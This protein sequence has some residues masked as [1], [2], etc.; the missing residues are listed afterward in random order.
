MALFQY[1]ALSP[2]GKK[3]IGLINADT[4]E[5]AKEQLRRQKILVTKLVLY[6]KQPGDQTLSSALLLNLTRDLHVLLRAGLPLYDSLLTLQEKYFRTKAHSLLLNL[7]DQVKE[8][9]HLSQAL[10]LYP[11]IFDDVYISMVRA[12]EESGTLTESFEELSKLI[13]RAQGLKK[14]ITTA[15]IY[16]LFL[17]S[18]CLVVIGALLFFLI[19]SMQELFEG[20]ALHPLTQTVLTLSSFLNENAFW[21]FSCAGLFALLSAFFMKQKSGKIFRQKMALRIPVIDRLTTEAVMTRFCRVVSVLLRGG[22]SLLDSLKLAKLVMQHHQFEEVITK[23][24]IKVV[25]GKKLS[26]ELEKSPL[27]P[28]LVIRMMAIAEES[29]NMAKMMQHVSEIYEEDLERSLSRLTS[30]MQPVILLFLGL[31]VAVILLSVLLPLTDVS[32]MIQ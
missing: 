26:E 10:A 27:I 16:P 2:N 19:P 14:K 32:S 12:G 7:C 21:I 28:H 4:L 23:A 30:F 17:G 11:R 22:V 18:F 29:G 24:E 20:R 9:Q 5:L 3:T 6:K 31:V 8:G 1:S 13:T 25:E 15:M